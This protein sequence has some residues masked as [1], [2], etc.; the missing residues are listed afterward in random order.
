VLIPLAA[1][2]LYSCILTAKKP[3][4][5][6]NCFKNI[7]GAAQPKKRNMWIII[8]NKKLKVNA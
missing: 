4:Q 5:T 8:T 2:N 1:K 7:N 6:K 3:G